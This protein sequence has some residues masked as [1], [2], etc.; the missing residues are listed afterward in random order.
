MNHFY[1]L[2]LLAIC[3]AVVFATISRDSRRERMRYFLSLVGF[4]VLGSLLASWV[5]WAIPW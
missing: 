4:M 1:G 3:I 2:F 5:M